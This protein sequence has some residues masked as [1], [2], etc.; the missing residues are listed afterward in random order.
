MNEQNQS[1]EISLKELIIKKEWFDYLI[2]KWKI[3]F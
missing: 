1:D 2:S 3:I